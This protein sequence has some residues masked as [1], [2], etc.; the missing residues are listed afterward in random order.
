MTFR[1]HTSPL[2]FE[3]DELGRLRR[4][5][6]GKNQLIRDAAD[7][8]RAVPTGHEETIDVGLALVSV[9]SES[10]RIPGLPFDPKRGVIANLEG[11]VTVGGEWLGNHYCTGWARTGA[12]GLIATQKAGA[13]E[14]A[15]RMLEDFRQGSVGEIKALDDTTFPTLLR[16]REIRWVSFEDWKA[17]DRAEIERGQARGAPRD[18]LVDVPA[19]IAVAEMSRRGW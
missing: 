18:K 11:R 2:A 15:T 1:F 9:G 6:V 4:L 12:R 14:I 13:L 8:L 16:Q 7:E 17:I 19:M 3:S 5:R 10:K